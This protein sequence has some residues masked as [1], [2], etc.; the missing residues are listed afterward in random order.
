VESVPKIWVLNVQPQLDKQVVVLVVGQTESITPQKLSIRN[1]PVAQ[2]HLT[3]LLVSV[4]TRLYLE[5]IIRRHFVQDDVPDLLHLSFGGWLSILSLNF[6]FQVRLRLVLAL[7]T[8]IRVV[9][10]DCVSL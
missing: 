9:Y 3:A 2:E 6:V 1:A 4:F 5:S 8:C 10:A 7:L